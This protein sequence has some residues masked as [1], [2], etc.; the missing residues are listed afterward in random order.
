LYYGRAQLVDEFFAHLG[1]DLPHRV[2]VADFI[3]DIA[4]GSVA[5][6]DR[7]DLWL[8]ARNPFNETMDDMSFAVA[9]AYV[10]VLQASAIQPAT[11]LL[12]AESATFLAY[13]KTSPPGEA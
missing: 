13:M 10:L 3:L 4:S 12:Y 6:A 5:S 11:L 1:Y 7:C 2:N 9:R 8:R